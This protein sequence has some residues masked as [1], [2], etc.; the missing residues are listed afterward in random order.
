[1]KK[2]RLALIHTLILF[3]LQATAESIL[4][5][6]TQGDVT[7]VSGGVGVDERNEMQAIR[8]EYNLS[9]LF[10]VQSTGEYLSGVKVSI[11]DS[12]GNLLLETVSDGP[13]LLA[14]LKPGRYNINAE[15]EGQI[16]Q[17]KANVEGNKRT[18]ISFIWPQQ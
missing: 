15:L 4:K 10:S 1:M 13:M 6:Q 11:V 17:K 12:K 14:K 3:S 8:A 16:A 2:C 18:S 5:P 9:V 7:F